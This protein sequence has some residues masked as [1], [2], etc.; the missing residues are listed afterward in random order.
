MEE[1]EM[2]CQNEND[3]VS[4]KLNYQ[5][6][7][8]EELLLE[9]QKNDETILKSSKIYKKYDIIVEVMGVLTFVGLGAF[10]VSSN[11]VLKLLGLLFGAVTSCAGLGVLGSKEYRVSKAEYEVACKLNKEIEE[12]LES[13]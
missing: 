1:K 4:E 9:K 6:M 5:E 12:E 7:S 10:V 3:N 11:N 8:E 13:R 2:N